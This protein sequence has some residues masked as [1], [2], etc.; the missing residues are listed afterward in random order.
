MADGLASDGVFRGG[1][2]FNVQIWQQLLW[3]CRFVRTWSALAEDERAG[4]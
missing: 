1:V 3:L 2:G 4:G